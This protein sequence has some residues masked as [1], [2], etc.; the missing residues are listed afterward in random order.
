MQEFEGHL[1]PVLYVSRKLTPPERNYA[2][3]ERECL[4]VVWSINKLTKYLAGAPFTLRTNH[5]PLKALNTKKLSNAK[6][7]RWALSLQDYQFDIEPIPGSQNVL[8]D[9]LSRM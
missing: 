5:A 7:T 4:A 6:L 3:I 1:H 9:A 8:A 2:V